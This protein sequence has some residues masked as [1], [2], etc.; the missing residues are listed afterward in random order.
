MWRRQSKNSASRNK[1]E[2]AMVGGSGDRGRL[3]SFVKGLRYGADNHYRTHLC[4]AP[5]CFR[6][7][8]RICSAPNSRPDRGGAGDSPGQISLCHLPP[9]QGKGL[10]RRVCRRR[11]GLPDMLPHHRRTRRPGSPAEEAKA[12]DK[13]GP[14]PPSPGEGRVVGD[15][16]G[17]AG[18]SRIH[19][20]QHHS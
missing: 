12:S 15:N 18:G 20:D 4:S 2:Q 14:S 10:L 3:S 7:S 6:S 11:T 19:R 17:D 13:A 9:E 8:G 5:G 1:G 16:R